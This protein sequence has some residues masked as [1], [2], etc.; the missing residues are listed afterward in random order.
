MNM[1]LSEFVEHLRADQW[2]L[3]RTKV[4]DSIKHLEAEN[5]RLKEFRNRVKQIMDSDRDLQDCCKAI[6]ELLIESPAN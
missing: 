2:Y 4:V 6:D 3:E 1:K 5:Q